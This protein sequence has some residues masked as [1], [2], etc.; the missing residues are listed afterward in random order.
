MVILRLCSI[1]KVL[2]DTFKSPLP[3]ES[4]YLLYHLF[5]PLSRVFYYL[6]S[7]FFTLASGDF[8]ILT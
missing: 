3:L 4:A 8:I 6:L 5:S 1:F 7:V 2:C